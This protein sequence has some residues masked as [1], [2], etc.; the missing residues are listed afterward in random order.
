MDDTPLTQAALQSIQD[1][2]Y[3][4]NASALPALLRI[5]GDTT[6][7]LQGE[8]L[9]VMR[10]MGSAIFPDLVQRAQEDPMMDDLLYEALVAAWA[11][12]FERGEE[13]PHLQVHTI[14]HIIDT[15]VQFPMED[16]VPLLDYVLHHALK[17][18]WDVA[19][20]IIGEMGYPRNMSFIPVVIEHAYS[21]NDPAQSDALQVIGTLGPEIMAP[22]FIERLWKNETSSS[23]TDMF[24]LLLNP[25]LG[26]EYVAPCGPLVVYRF[27]QFP[28]SEQKV[29]GKLFLRVL[30]KIGPECAIY[31]LPTL[32]DLVR[33]EGTSDVAQRARRLIASF[34][35]Q[36]L[37][38]YRVLIDSLGTSPEEG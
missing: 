23:R 5:A 22:Y 33:K 12:V 3:P 2:G 7:P 6:S 36:V 1:T 29:V 15:F 37:A 27:S 35:E 13:K 4:R 18:W 11:F 38:P 9:H 19:L 34:D 17:E 14:R 21:Y 25:R 8:A 26:Q 32:L 30:E 20:R 16:T 10:A 31:A 28:P 24:E